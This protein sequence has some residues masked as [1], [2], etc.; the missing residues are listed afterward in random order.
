MVWS[1]VG[2]GGK[3]SG[4]EVERDTPRQLDAECVIVQPDEVKVKAR[5][6]TGHKELLV[7]TA[8][9]QS[10]QGTRYFSAASARAAEPSGGGVARG[11]WS[12]RWGDEPA[13]ALATERGGFGPGMTR[14]RLS[15]R[16]WCCVGITW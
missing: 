15:T 9:V 4:E 14:R 1:L 13:D 7:Y 10:R 12:G 5:P 16:R 2:F 8:V 6:G 3:A 11:A